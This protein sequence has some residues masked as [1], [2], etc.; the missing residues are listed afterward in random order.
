MHYIAPYCSIAN[1]L[2]NSFTIPDIP[3][4]IYWFIANRIHLL[5]SLWIDPLCLCHVVLPAGAQSRMHV[6][7]STSRSQSSPSPGQSVFS[8]GRSIRVSMLLP[9]FTKSSLRRLYY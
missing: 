5:W 7:L 4:V 3:G 2:P 6:S 1:K 9:L 8:K